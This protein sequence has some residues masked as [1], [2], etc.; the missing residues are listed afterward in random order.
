MDD[1]NISKFRL[2]G[3]TALSKESPVN[4]DKFRVL[5][6][7]SYDY[8]TKQN[9]INAV[10]MDTLKDDLLKVNNSI[11]SAYSNWQTKE[12]MKNTQS[13]IKSMYTRLTTLQ[14]LCKTNGIT[15]GEKEL[16]EVVE[17][18]KSTLDGWNDLASY[19]NKFKT[20][21]AYNK[22]NLQIKKLNDEYNK[23]KNDDVNAVKGELNAWEKELEKI[24]NGKE[25]LS[26]DEWRTNND[27]SFTIPYSATHLPEVFAGKTLSQAEEIVKNKRA[28]LEKAIRI[29]EDEKYSKLVE[30]GEGEK[31][32]KKWLEYAKDTNDYKYNNAT[33]KRTTFAL[34]KPIRAVSDNIIFNKML[35]TSH[36]RPKDDWTKKELYQFGARWD[37]NNPDIAY[38]YAIRVNNENAIEQKNIAKQKAADFAT[39]N[40]ATGAI[41][42]IGSIL[43][44]TLAV[45][46]Y[47][48][49]LTDKAAHRNAIVEEPNLTPFEWATASTGAISEKLNQMGTLDSN[50]PII[51]GKGWGD[52]YALGG[53]IAQ[54]AAL[55]AIGGPWLTA[56]SFFGQGAADAV[57]DATERGATIDEALCYG[58]IVGAAEMVSEYIGADKLLKVGKG[59]ILSAFKEIL[60][61]AGAEGI[62]EMFSE[63]INNIADNVIMGDKSRFNQLVNQYKAQGFSEQAAASM[64]WT[65]TIEEI[66]YSG[67]SGMLSGGV[68]A[69]PVVIFNKIN[70]AYLDMPLTNGYVDVS[71]ID[72]SNTVTNT[73]K[74]NNGN[75]VNWNDLDFDQQTAIIGVSNFAKNMGLN[76]TWISDGAKRGMNGA[77]EITGNKMLIDVNAGKTKLNGNS[78]ESTIIPTASHEMVHWVKNK[79]PEIYAKLENFVFETFALQGISN[80]SVVAKRRTL[81]EKA[82]KDV[83][84]TNEDVIEEV[85]ARACEDMLQ[86]SKKFKKCLYTMNTLQQKT[87]LGKL[88][89]TFNSIKRWINNFSSES[90]SNSDE[91]QIIR[92]D[93]VRFKQQ[94]NLYEKMLIDASQLGEYNDFYDTS[95]TNST[96]INKI[97]YS[98][99][100]TD[101]LTKPNIYEYAKRIK[102]KYNSNIDEGVIMDRLKAITN[103][104]NLPQDSLLQAVYNYSENEIGRLNQTQRLINELAVEIAQGIKPVYDEYAN[105]VLSFIKGDNLY[106]DRNQRLKIKYMYGSLTDY[107][108]R[109]GIKL[110]NPK[111]P[112]LDEDWVALTDAWQYWSDGYPELFSNKIATEDMPARLAEVMEYLNSQSIETDYDE[113]AQNIAREL[114][115]EI[116]GLDYYEQNKETIKCYIEYFAQLYR[117]K[118]ITSN[119]YSSGNV[120]DD[121]LTLKER[122]VA[123]KHSINEYECFAWVLFNDILSKENVETLFGC[124]ADYKNKKIQFSQTKFG[125]AIV[126][127]EEC[128]DV[129]VYIKGPA[130]N[131]VVTQIVQINNQDNE[132]L[133]KIKNMI[134]LNEKEQNIFSM[135]T[136]KKAFG[137]NA[138]TV[139][140]L[141]NYKSYWDYQRWLTNKKKKP[142]KIKNEDAV[143]K[144]KIDEEVDYAELPSS[145]QACFVKCTDEQAIARAEKMELQGKRPLD[146][147]RELKIVRGIFGDWVTTIAA[148]G[149]RLYANGTA[150]TD[151]HTRNIRLKRTGGNIEGKLSDFLMWKQLY[152]KFPHFKDVSVLLTDAK[153]SYDTVKYLPIR[154]T[155]VVDKKLCEEF[156]KKKN[157]DLIA[158][159]LREVQR[160][161]QIEEGKYIGKNRDYWVDQERAGKLPFS[162]LLN[163]YLTAD[164][165]MKYFIDNYEAEMV[166]KMQI[167]SDL[168]YRTAHHAYPD[169]SEIMLISPDVEPDKAL[170]FDKDENLVSV[171]EKDAID[172]NNFFK[173]Y[174]TTEKYTKE[175]YQK[176]ET[177]KDNSSINEAPTKNEGDFFTSANN[178]QNLL[179][180]D[181]FSKY[182]DNSLNKGE[183][184]N[185]E[186][187]ELLARGAISAANRGDDIL[188]Q[189]GSNSKTLAECLGMPKGTNEPHIEA[190]RAGECGWL[191]KKSNSASKETRKSFNSGILRRIRGIKLSGKDTVGGI[192]SPQ[193]LDEFKDTICKDENG[194]LISLYH[195]TTEIFETFKKGEFGFHFGTLNAARDRYLQLKEETPDISAGVFKEVILNITNPI[196]INDE[197][198][199]WNANWVAFHLLQK[200]IIDEQQYNDLSKLSGF[201]KNTYDNPAAKAVREI[202][203]K[204][205]YDGIIYENLSEDVGSY[206]LIVLYPEQIITVS[207]N[208][209][210]KENSGISRATLETQVTSLNS[211]DKSANIINAD[212]VI[213]GIRGEDKRSLGDE[214]D[215]TKTRAIPELVDLI[216]RLSNGEDINIDEVNALSI[217]KKLE[218]ESDLN[219]STHKNNSN[220]RQEIRKEIIENLLR[221]G[222][223]VIDRHRRVTY[224]G[225]VKQ[226]YRAD[227]VIGLPGSGKSSTLAEPLSA[228]YSSRVIDSDMVKKML[229][230]YNGGIGA[231]VVH[232]ES[233]DINNIILQNALEKGDNI[234]Y[235]MIGGGKVNSLI[236]KIKMF[237][238]SGYSVYLHLNELPNGKAIA[239]SLNRYIE[240]GRFISPKV[241]EQYGDTPTRNFYTIINAEENLDGRQESRGYGNIN[242]A[243]V[244][245]GIWGKDERTRISETE[246]GGTT[247]I[248][249][250]R[251]S[252]TN[253]RRSVF[254]GVLRTDKESRVLRSTI[255]GTKEESDISGKTRNLH[256]SSYG[257]GLLR[258]IDGYSHYSND[259]ERGEIPKLINLSENVREFAEQREKIK[260]YNQ[261]LEATS[262]EGDASF[263]S[264]NGIVNNATEQRD[265]MPAVAY[266]SY[267]DNVSQSE[268]SRKVKNYVASTLKTRAQQQAYRL[269]NIMAGDSDFVS[270]KNISLNAPQFLNNDKINISNQDTIGRK[271]DTNIQNKLYATIAKNNMGEPISLYI[272]NKYGE[273]LLR[274]QQLG[275]LTGS[276][277]MAIEKYNA[278]NNQKN[279]I[280]IGACEEYYANIN[281]PI[282]LPFEPYELSVQEVGFYL[283]EIGVLSREQYFDLVDNYYSAKNAPQYNNLVTRKLREIL[284]SL[285]YDSIIYKNQNY[286]V[287][288]LAV[289]VLEPQRLIP[290]AKNGML[291]GTPGIDD[292]NYTD[293]V[294]ENTNAAH[295]TKLM[296]FY[297]QD[298]M[299]AGRKNRKQADM[300]ITAGESDWFDKEHYN[301]IA[302]RITQMP[303]V[304]YNP[305]V[306]EGNRSF[307]NKFIKEFSNTVFKDDNGLPLSS[308]IWSKKSISVADAV[309]DMLCFKSFNNAFEDFIAA[310][311]KNATSYNGVF[312]EYKINSVNPLLLELDAFNT[313][314]IADILY[315]SG[316]MSENTYN[317]IYTNASNDG[318]SRRAIKKLKNAIELLGYDSIIFAGKN[319]KNTVLAFDEAQVLPIAKNGILLNNGAISL[320]A[321][322]EQI[323]D[324]YVEERVV[325]NST[326]RAARDFDAIK[327]EILSLPDNTQ[328]LKQLTE[329]LE[330]TN[331][332]VLQNANSINVGHSGA[333]DVKTQN[334]WSAKR[335]IDALILD[336]QSSTLS[337]YDTAGRAVP[338]KTLQQFNK[339]IFKDSNG[340]LLS[341]FLWNKY[342]QN[343]HLHSAFAYTMGNLSFARDNYVA[344]RQKHPN[345]K[346]GTY[347]EYY[348][349]AKNIYFMM[350]TPQHITARAIADDMYENGVIS[351]SEYRVITSRE[352]IDWYNRD[353]NAAKYLR[354]VL[355]EK[356]VDAIAYMNTRYDTGSI[357]VIVLSEE[358]LQLVSENGVVNS[359]RNGIMKTIALSR[360]VNSSDDIYVNSAKI[361]PISNF[362][363]M[364]IHG[365]AFGFQINDKD[366]NPIDNYNALEFANI[367]K[368][369]PNYRGGNIRLISCE[370]G[371]LEFGAAQILANELGVDVLAPTDIVWVTIDGEMIVGPSEFENTGEWKIFNPKRRK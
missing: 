45:S 161:I 124:Y 281:N 224:N 287:G 330:C 55:T 334:I 106:L 256:G 4:L 1:I 258:L 153:Y 146:I 331:K 193:I 350:Q 286:D 191:V 47:V 100:S 328:K 261:V 217:V 134:L 69:A 365:D 214:Q 369:D 72:F 58:T 315:N 189:P 285:G 135:Q 77:Y 273:N 203:A 26:N 216:E 218:C 223:A 15:D 136:V 97:K 131:P 36:E 84:Y 10:G 371:S 343:R 89:E 341:L 119:K 103:N 212:E 137:E 65:K 260:D 327:N 305:F 157:R 170:T 93:M 209:V 33:K 299:Y 306:S 309:N 63:T 249:E 167:V 262:N 348:V 219:T 148:D 355:K 323:L 192:V 82:H 354:E 96:Q 186:N 362:E 269:N 290:V 342:D 78:F 177:L 291:I 242:P 278:E 228:F 180:K 115:E 201:N 298:S 176:D 226:E 155:I 197:M 40:F 252:A 83:A 267:S 110:S 25:W 195:W 127:F 349:N 370:S 190:I 107:H 79:S 128:P 142:V 64:A 144:S 340:N 221:N 244:S 173:D 51:G 325:I 304:E 3:D 238:K 220:E 37:E 21:D 266:P 251:D 284:K 57:N 213:E 207:E 208:G 116:Y 222:S 67:L 353:N 182:N 5:D 303:D 149:I 231:G 196:E 230:E 151:S 367:I 347:E 363:D 301:K 35:D 237:K 283:T 364:V 75:Q 277:D 322:D 316:K 31:G 247:G 166:A 181:N 335:V 91:A 293:N 7:K 81:M 61:Q 270:N 194:N 292:S 60:K 268:N 357:G 264:K 71:V 111:N 346:K 300:R 225:N 310:K 198:G 139:H 59:E 294:T 245:E 337:Q 105:E 114:Y 171:K 158:Y 132:M 109:V 11:Q 206:S 159:M 43:A 53:S 254:R 275:I 112:S 86:D 202:L 265:A 174:K 263:S 183:K 352:G 178:R 29:Q 345:L 133:S 232:K 120:Y 104:K 332:P 12:Q 62:E 87:V 282:I 165:M 156:L 118:Q 311:A 102:Q 138:I 187:A 130:I 28:Y 240:E 18:Y 80:E 368:E 9:Q 188:R 318:Q 211:E 41:A 172:G 123:K 39:K 259:V 215:T 129:L 308:Y 312:Y 16:S 154:N 32:Y 333:L 234:V 297:V 185:G 317:Q 46:D 126:F 92:K 6:T 235:Q 320:N 253:R 336:S 95:S 68:H 117:E 280:T 38:N 204:N 141:E 22:N 329:H 274:Y 339:T 250:Y 85:V 48:D 19:Y 74:T 239:R 276:I 279:R 145:R 13:D 66:A 8:Y 356:G 326:G 319:G 17:A 358:N 175:P 56:V 360:Y 344:E 76:V 296:R 52:L 42:T 257:R 233:V 359:V 150:K 143:D 248:D 272:I 169:F 98:D 163:R 289:V 160:M 121:L 49:D 70:K 34:S 351:K 54:S 108:N 243:D 50:I 20:A 321:F 164:D 44:K 324:E 307:N 184:Y 205:G 246:L 199:E 73:V 99:I 14:N 271:L 113:Q 302:K 168:I 125:E 2:G 295:N 24:L 200:G 23:A 179:D 152:K 255:L 241:I 366:G 30:S 140:K 94:I 288:S 313:L 27:G 88:T 210:L 361:K 236:N 338:K 101:G 227:I 314:A 122:L 90:H 147:W 229:P 162:K